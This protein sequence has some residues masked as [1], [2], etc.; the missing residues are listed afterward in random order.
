MS[1]QGDLIENIAKRYLKIPYSVIYKND[2]RSDAIK[3]FVDEYKADSAIDI[4]LSGCHTYVI[5]TNKIKEASKEKL[6]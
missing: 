1:T 3:K 5:E 2:A 6:V 4:V